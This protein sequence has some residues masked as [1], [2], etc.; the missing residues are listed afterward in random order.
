M[1]QLGNVAFELKLPAD[2]RIHPVFHSSQLKPFH[3][4]A[5]IANTDTPEVLQLYP[6]PS[7]IA[8]LDWKNTADATSILVQWS[9]TFPEDATWEDLE[10]IK[11]QYPDLH[12]EDNVFLEDEEDVMGPIAEKV[13]QVRPK[14]NKVK[15]KYLNDYETS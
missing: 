8:I 14:R 4:P 3:G 13:T 2:A 6:A 9:N 7:P 12:L 10:T 1:K 15:P 11:A 5:V